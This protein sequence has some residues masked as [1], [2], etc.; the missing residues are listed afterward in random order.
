VARR[1]GGGG[2]GGGGKTQKP[3]VEMEDFIKSCLTINIVQGKVLSQVPG[4]AGV[5]KLE[6]FQRA[7]FCDLL[8]SASDG[9]QDLCDYTFIG[10][11]YNDNSLWNQLSIHLKMH[12]FGELAVG[13]LVPNT[14]LPPDTVLHYAAYD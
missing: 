3:Q 6:G 1:R 11:E 5:G 7:L 8:S 9:L 12:L 4:W 13:L 10:E 14:P 2:G